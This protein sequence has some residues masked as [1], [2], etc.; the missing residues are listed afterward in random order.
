[1]PSVIFKK[2]DRIGRVI[3]NRPNKMNAINDSM[4]KEIEN[5]I[6]L[7]DSDPDIHVIIL[8]FVYFYFFIENQGW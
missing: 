4:P 2:E 3:L 6:Q 5:A 7:A 1:M 8:S